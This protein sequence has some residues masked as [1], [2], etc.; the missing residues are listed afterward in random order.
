MVALSIK[1]NMLFSMSLATV[2]IENKYQYH[3][4]IC[5]R[6]I[7]LIWLSFRTNKIR[8]LL[9]CMLAYSGSRAGNT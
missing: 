4:M 3:I 1:C 5:V 8:E 9:T 6:H 7:F 2:I